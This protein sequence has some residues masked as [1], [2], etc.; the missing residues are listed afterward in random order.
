[1]AGVLSGFDPDEF[2][3]A[4]HFVQQMAAPEDVEQQAT[5]YFPVPKMAGGD[6]EGVPFDIT[7]PIV[8]PTPTKAPVRVPCSV[9]YVDGAGRIENFGLLVPSK[10]IVTLLDVDYT[11]VQGFSFVVINGTRYW[12]SDTEPPTGLCTVTIYNVHCKAEDEG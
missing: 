12:Y 9:K 4:I 3:T 8:P 6:S 10:V 7:K 2:R 5:F 11:Q 1:M